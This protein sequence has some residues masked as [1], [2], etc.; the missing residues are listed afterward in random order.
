MGLEASETEMFLKL[1]REKQQR[2]LAAA[3]NEFADKGYARASMNVVVEKA[4]I[5]KGALFKYFRSKGGLFAFVYKM[6]LNRVKDDLRGVRDESKEAP[7]FDR[8][9]RIMQAGVDFIHHHPGLA[10]IYYHIMFT[11]D[12]PYK[13]EILGEI[14]GES[15]KFIQALI[16]QGMA[17]G[18]LRRDL[19]PESVAFVLGSVLDRFLQ[20]HNLQFLAQPLGLYHASS[21]DSDRWIREIVRLFKKGLEKPR[22][23][24]DEGGPS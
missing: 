13:N 10:R 9:Q 23:L 6:A 11:G 14:H 7:F 15:L 3:I 21:E 16:E 4:G 17:R 24:F 1:S 2:I 18:E 12:S 5:S 22:A 20:A 19:D 8:L